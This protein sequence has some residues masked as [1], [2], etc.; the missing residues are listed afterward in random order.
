M[1]IVRIVVLTVAMAA[2]A[3]TPVP[4]FK[5]YAYPSWGFA[6]S[7]RGAPTVTDTPAAPDGS[8]AHTLLVESSLA[9]RDDLVNV[10]DGS[11]SAKS[12][13]QALADAPATLAG[14]VGGTLGPITYAATGE[15]IGREFVLNRQGRPP[16]RVRIFVANKHLYELIAQSSLGTDDPETA[17][18]L[19]SFRLLGS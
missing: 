9:G 11:S 10:I 18:F 2:W 6:V 15:T 7:F 8:T 19:T 4:P 17:N 16:A 3:C 14:S 12:E 1:R 5:A 13:D